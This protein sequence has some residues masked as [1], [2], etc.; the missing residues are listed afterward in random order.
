[1]ALCAE[2]INTKIL[3]SE[4]LGKVCNMTGIVDYSIF[5]SILSLENRN[6]TVTGGHTPKF[7]LIPWP[8]IYNGEGEYLTAIS[9]DP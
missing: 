5:P 8:R 2:I 6:P 9:C 4:I 1:M 3:W 7:N